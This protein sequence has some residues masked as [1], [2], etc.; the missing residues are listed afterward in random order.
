MVWLVK[1]ELLQLAFHRL[2]MCWSNDWAYVIVVSPENPVF[3]PVPDQSWCMW[4]GGGCY[5]VGGGA[6]LCSHTIAHVCKRVCVCVLSVVFAS[7]RIGVEA[8]ISCVVAY[9]R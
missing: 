2:R 3:V 5:S 7:V 6:L 9:G 8:R 4:E 1:D